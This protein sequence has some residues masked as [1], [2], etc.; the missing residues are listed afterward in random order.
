MDCTRIIGVIRIIR[1][2]PKRLLGKNFFKNLKGEKNLIINLAVKRTLDDELSEDKEAVC[3]MELHDL[4]T[5]I[6]HFLCEMTDFR[7]ACGQ[8]N[9]AV[10]GS[11]SHST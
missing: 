8:G 9:P 11:R 4:K 3:G 10:S 2:R 6:H 1:D 7:G 5:R